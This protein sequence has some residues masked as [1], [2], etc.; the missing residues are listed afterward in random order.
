MMLRGGVLGEAG[1]K[2]KPEAS[3]AGAAETAEAQA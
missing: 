3:A 1:G 2:E